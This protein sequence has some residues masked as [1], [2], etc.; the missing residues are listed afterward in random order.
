MREHNSS[1]TDSAS[2]ETIRNGSNVV[3]A[4][5]ATETILYRSSTQLWVWSG[6]KAKVGGFAIG[7]TAFMAGFFTVALLR[8]W[9][10]QREK[11]R[12][13]EDGWVELTTERIRARSAGETEAA[14]IPYGFIRQLRYEGDRVAVQ[15]MDGD[16][17]KV[18]PADAALFRTTLEQ[19]ARP[20]LWRAL[21][22]E[23]PSSQ[24]PIALQEQRA[25][26]FGFGVPAGW[27]LVPDLQAVSAAINESVVAGA[28][29]DLGASGN[30]HVI[31][32]RNPGP[33]RRDDI[34]RAACMFPALVASAG[35]GRETLGPPPRVPAV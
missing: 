7:T 25:G 14:E 11:W 34:E 19:V 5:S 15:F 18:R 33:V 29:R 22:L 3:T 31:V 17:I 24:A 8:K 27:T 23:K 2:S 32:Q 35:P 6:A 16:Q 21:P 30:P 13:I 4:P 12:Q 10:A 9:N 20:K 26:T 1:L 28:V